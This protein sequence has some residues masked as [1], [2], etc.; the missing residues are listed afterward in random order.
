MTVGISAFL[1]LENGATRARLMIAVEIGFG[2]FLGVFC[3][4]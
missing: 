3:L 2:L 4:T 1:A